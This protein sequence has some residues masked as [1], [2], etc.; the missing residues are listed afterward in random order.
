MNENEA[1]QFVVDGVAVRRQQ[2]V[3]MKGLL[4]KHFDNNSAAML[5]RAVQQAS[6]SKPANLILHQTIDPVPTLR[7]L[8]EW[9]SWWIAGCEAL[10]GL[11]H[12]NLLLPVAP[13]MDD[14]EP[15]IQWTTVVP[16]SGSGRSAGW[17]FPEF[18]ISYPHLLTRSR[19]LEVPQVLCDGDLFLRELSLPHLHP[20]VEEALKEAISCFRSELYTAAVVMLGKASEGSWI[21]T[22]L[23]LLSAVPESEASKREKLR[24]EWGGTD[25][26]FA[27]KMRDIVKLYETRQDLFKNIG[28]IANVR[29]DELRMAMLWSDS[30]RDA[31][32]VVHHNVDTHI[33]PTF[34]MV[35]TL[36][37]AALP[38]L[39]VLH[40]LTNA[41]KT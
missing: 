5:E 26:G 11:V 21:E 10:W 13:N 6:P 19:N 17:D 2:I 16:G 25:V 12:S 37:L 28:S 8:S 4:L 34:D 31:R 1:R 24:Q 35:S 36:F 41:V 23:A 18:K 33:N 15:V 9:I 30:L 14:F 7:Q 40:R 22:G 20:E 27:K 29:L 32:N 3:V 39:K 38:N